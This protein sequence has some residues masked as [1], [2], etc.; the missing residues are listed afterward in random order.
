MVNLG[1][2]LGDV[3]ETNKGTFIVTGIQFKGCK[4]IGVL[5]KALVFENDPTH[6]AKFL[7][8]DIINKN[9]KNLKYKENK[10]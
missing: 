3:F 1:L 6:Q 4:R 2:V 8:D 10:L 5:I 7:S 9:Y